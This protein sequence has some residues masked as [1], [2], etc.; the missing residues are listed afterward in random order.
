MTR[1]IDGWVTL[2]IRK[3]NLAAALRPARALGSTACF[4]RAQ[5]DAISG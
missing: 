3:I 4:R 5:A 2:A 1:R